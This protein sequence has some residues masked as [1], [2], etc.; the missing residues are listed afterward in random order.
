MKYV[1]TPFT[2]HSFSLMAQAPPVMWTAFAILPNTT[3]LL[4]CTEP[5][6]D[7][8]VNYLPSELL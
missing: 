8:F 2:A 7:W 5:P 4:L 6:S 1:Y 3:T